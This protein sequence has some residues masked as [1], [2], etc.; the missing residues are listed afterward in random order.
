MKT[1]TEFSSFALKTA[2]EA[3]DALATSG[4]TPE[5]LPAALGEQLKLE[6]DKL[7]WMVAAIDVA[8]AKNKNL[9]RILVLVLNE[10]EAAPKGAEVKE[11]FVLLPEMFPSAHAPA[12]PQKDDRRDG[13]RGGKRGDK[14]GGGRDGK[15]GGG[16]D[17]KPGGGRDGKPG[18]GARGPR[19]DGDSGPRRDANAGPRP[20]VAAG[21]PK[22]AP[23]VIKP[24]APAAAPS[25]D[26]T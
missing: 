2:I 7:N 15:P 25:G 9:K 16:R 5:E 10:G 6:G 22:P 12:A 4:K 26:A 1:M 24:K 17:G 23:V 3:A 18:G 13:K 11:G 8:R 19:R 21:G 20:A 14:R